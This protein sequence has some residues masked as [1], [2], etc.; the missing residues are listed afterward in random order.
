M[1]CPV[2]ITTT[3]FPLTF[4]DPDSSCALSPA[5]PAADAGSTQIPAAASAFC[6]ARIWSSLTAI[7]FPPDSSAA[8]SACS[9]RAGFPIRIAVAIVSGFSTTWPKTSGAAPAA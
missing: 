2:Q 4:S 5:N 6:A 3:R 9:P 7:I 8:A 1:P